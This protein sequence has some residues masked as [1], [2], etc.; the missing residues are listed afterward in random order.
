MVPV[1][2]DAVGNET[3]IGFTFNFDQARFSNPQVSL[4]NGV[5]QGATLVTNLSEAAAGRVGVVVN[6]L[7]PYAPGTRQIVNVSLQVAANTPIGLSPVSFGNSPVTQSVVD[8]NQQQLLTSYQSG[9][10]QIGSSTAGVSISGRVLTPNGNGLRNATVNL[11]DEQGIRRIATTSSFGVFQ[12][13]N[14]PAG[15]TY[16]I[17][18]GSKRYRFAPTFLPVVDTVSDIVLV[19]LE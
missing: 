9:N 4:G 16:L 12:F 6:S 18:V 14:V 8:G 19:G 1:E 15:E 7:N 17:T 11:I 10:I 5:P 13:D 3:N 2:I